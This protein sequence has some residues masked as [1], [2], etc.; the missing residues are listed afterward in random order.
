VTEASL[1]EQQLEA[2]ERPRN[3]RATR[4][5]WVLVV[6][7]LLAIVGL[8]IH[9]YTAY[10]TIARIN[11]AARIDSANPIAM[12]Q[13]IATDGPRI[14]ATVEASQ[15]STYSKALE[16]FLLDGTGLALGLVLVLAGLFI[17]AN[18]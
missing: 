11:S 10:A 4:L 18:L 14:G 15:R 16:Q 2:M 1:I 12:F 9:G 6:V 5:P 7:G 17:R 13:D 8:G 3:A